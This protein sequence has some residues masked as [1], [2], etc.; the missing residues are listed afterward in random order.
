MTVLLK[1]KDGVIWTLFALV[2]GILVGTLATVFGRVL[3]WIGELRS[4]HFLI[5]LPFLSLVGM[6]IVLIYQRYGG[7]AGKGMALIFEVGHGRDDEIPKR[8]IPLVMVTTWLT[9]LFGGSAGREGVAVQLGATVS[10]QLGKSYF[11]RREQKRLIVMGMA[12]GFAGL[13]QTPLAA[14][15]FAMEILVVGSL[16]VS[17]FWPA[18]VAA[19]VASFISHSLGLERFAFPLTGIPDLTMELFFKLILLGVLFGLCGNAFAW[20]LAHLKGVVSQWFPSPY[21]RIVVLGFVLSLG[22]LVLGQGRYAGLGTNLIAASFS[23]RGIAAYDWFFKLIFTVVTLAAGYQGG[24]V[25]PLFAIGASLGV[26]LAPFFGLPL[27]FVAA[28]GYAGVFAGASSTFLGPI[29]IGCEVFG[30]VHFPAFFIVCSLAFLLNRSQSI[31][32]LQKVAE[33]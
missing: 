9:H 19:V 31:Y 22:L 33:S 25:T 21:R 28:L 14:T 17:A 5:F 24:E 27:V 23:G 10:Y 13:F 15:L 7:N 30:F 8:L 12:A 18:L 29:L 6:L 1:V 16:A 2:I 32:S 20:S 4:A 11:S 3:L 26:F